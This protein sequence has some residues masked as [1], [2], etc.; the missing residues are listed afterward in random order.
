M[1]W[2]LA[3]TFRTSG[4]I[5]MRG[6]GGRR[7]RPPPGRPGRG[8]VEC[9]RSP[10][11]GSP[12]EYFRNESIGKIHASHETVRI[13]T[14]HVHRISTLSCVNGLR[15]SSHVRVRHRVSLS[16]APSLSRSLRAADRIACAATRQHALAP[17]VIRS[18]LTPLASRHAST[19]HTSHTSQS[20]R[21]THAHTPP[22][23]W[24]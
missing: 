20:S 2:R 6:R 18:P 15:D 13:S 1:M 3:E 12:V 21:A 9:A 8:C 4:A 17:L 5:G 23:T 16:L 14:E 22:L 11:A 10:A 7:G 19:S 24:G